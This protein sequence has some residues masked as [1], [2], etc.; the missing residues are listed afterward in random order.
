MPVQIIG[1]AYNSTTNIDMTQGNDGSATAAPIL[2]GDFILLFAVRN[3]SSVPAITDPTGWNTLFGG[4]VTRS[5]GG[6][7][8]AI[9][10]YWKF[11]QTTDISVS[12]PNL[13]STNPGYLYTGIFA[14]GVD[15][16]NPFDITPNVAVHVTQGSGGNNPAP[17]T[18]VTRGASA[19]AFG[20]DWTAGSDNSN[21]RWNTGYTQMSSQRTNWSSGVSTHCRQARGKFENWQSGVINGGTTN[22]FGDG[23]IA[24][25]FALRPE[26][27]GGNVKVWNG[28]T[29]AAKPAKVWNGSAW[30]TKPVKY[31]NGTTWVT[32]KY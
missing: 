19:I 30:V 20:H 25:V 9:R 5:G 16:T 8:F 23:W 4:Q 29:Q 27:S 24:A 10:A 18:P 26:G 2:V 21:F 1:T 6:K 12:F 28:S 17:L 31:W 3:S 22:G 32:T 15:K 7:N 13:G 14:R 11:R